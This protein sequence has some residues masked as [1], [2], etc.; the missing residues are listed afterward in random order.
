MIIVR[1]TRQ[2]INCAFAD[3]LYK[4]FYESLKQEAVISLNS[5]TVCSV[6]RK[7]RVRYEIPGAVNT[8]VT[9]CLRDVVSYC[10]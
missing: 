9:Y 1:T 3:E 2:N 7:H 5:V 10:S 4:C 6:E 8:Q